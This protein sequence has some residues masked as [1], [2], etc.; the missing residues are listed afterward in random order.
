[1]L[2][3]SL[4]TACAS[5]AQRD[6]RVAKRRPLILISID[7]FRA[8]YL[9]R[10]LT[11]TLSALAAQGARAEWMRPSFPSL[12]FPNHYTLITGLR[13]DRHGIVSNTMEDRRIP[14]Q[15]FAAAN[16]DAIENARWWEGA[17][18]LWTTAQRHGLRAAT[19]FWPGSEAPVHGAHPDY[20]ARFDAGISESARVDTVLGWLDLPEH[21]RPSLITLYFNSIDAIGHR[22]GPDSAEVDAALQAIDENIA[23]LLTG[24]D[25]RGIRGRANLVI[26]SDHGMTATSP[27]RVI[28][29]DD[30]VPEGMAHVVMWGVLTGIVPKRENRDAVERSLVRPHAHMQ[31]M[32]KSDVPARL[33]YGRNARI[34]PLLCIAEHGWII[35]DRATVAREK[36]F[37]LGE[38]GYDIDHPEMRSLFVGSGPAFRTG[39][40]LPPFDNVDVYPLLAK[41]LGVRA[42]P[43]DGD[44]ASTRAAL[45]QQ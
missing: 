18:P 31:C 10:A 1:M 26:V 45:R 7:G 36:H 17:V 35:F 23:R 2:L 44:I 9:E 8:D 12:T 15:R 22:H 43:N 14:S 27:D 5:V 25:R 41:L 6:A 28:Y 40:V 29:L 19:M 20:W 33:H 3:T 24:L 32:R 16:R 42:Q 11:P 4:L 37:S 39:V 30:V 21:E 38:H 34:P 13:P